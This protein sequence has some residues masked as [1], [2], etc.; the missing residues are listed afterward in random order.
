MGYSSLGKKVEGATLKE[1]SKHNT[2]LLLWVIFHGRRK[3]PILLHENLRNFSAEYLK[4]K[5]GHFGYLFI[6]TINTEAGHVGVVPNSR[7]R[8]QLAGNEKRTNK[9]CTCVCISV[10]QPSFK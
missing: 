4:D 5:L 7:K 6:G 10:I 3:T 2:L 8:R 1:D 9:Q